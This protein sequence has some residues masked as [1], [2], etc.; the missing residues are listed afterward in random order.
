[1]TTKER[2]LLSHEVSDSM[3]SRR[4]LCRNALDEYRMG[5]TVMGV[6]LI[7]T[8]FALGFSVD[9]ADMASRA[10]RFIDELVGEI[11]RRQA[12]TN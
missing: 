5:L 10:E 7:R 2:L 12:E 11:H 3:D 8:M 4:P 9:G 1:M 6:G